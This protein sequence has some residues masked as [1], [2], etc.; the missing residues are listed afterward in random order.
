MANRI[1]NLSNRQKY[2]RRMPLLKKNLENGHSCVSKLIVSYSLLDVVVDCCC[3]CS[4]LLPSLSC[5][6]VVEY[7]CYYLVSKLILTSKGG[8]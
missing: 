3:C 2:L 5:L 1:E 7:H 4:L 8:V 6:V